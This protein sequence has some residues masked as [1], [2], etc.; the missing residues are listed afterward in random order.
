MTSDFDSCLLQPCSFWLPENVVHGR[1][2]FLRC[3]NLLRSLHFCSLSKGAAISS[4][5]S[6]FALHF[7]SL[8]KGAAISSAV[9]GFAL[10]FCSLSRG[11]AISSAV[12][13]FALI[14]RTF[15]GVRIR[16]QQTDSFPKGAAICSAVFFWARIWSVFELCIGP[17]P[18]YRDRH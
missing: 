17:N 16:G 1:F 12:S 7:C 8:S 6:G 11:A 13:G 3:G 15:A 2:V 14:F 5:V 9:S 18:S 4:A 10:Q